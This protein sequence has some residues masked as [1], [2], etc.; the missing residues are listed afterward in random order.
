M[1]RI[2]V[3]GHG[4]VGHRFCEKLVEHDRDRRHRLI[5]FGREPRPAYDRVHLTEYFAHRDASRLRLGT[6]AWY[7]QHGIELRVGTPI[8]RIDR[9]R[10][11]VI[12]DGGDAFDYD[13][14]VLAT[15]SAPFVPP[16]HG[17]DTPG[18]YVYRTIEDLD[19]IAAQLGHA[20]RAVV[21]GGGLLGLEAA[22]AVLDAGLETHVLEV[23]PRLMP[24]QLDAVGGALLEASIRRLGVHV[25]LGARIAAITGGD[26]VREV[27]LVGEPAIPADLV[28]VSAGIQPCDEL[29]RDAGILTGERGGV[30]VD[31]RLRTSDEHVFAIGEVALHDGTIY[32]LVAPGY[33]MAE[34]LARHLIGEDAAFRGA[35]RS[36]K[37]KLLGTDVA[38]FGDPFRDPRNTKVVAYEDQLRGV[39]QKLVL[40]PDGRQLVG[41]ILVGDTQ[42]YVRLVHLARTGVPVDGALPVF[43]RSAA[44]S[45]ELADDAP[46]CSC[47]HVLAG[48]IRA[49][50]RAASLSTVA[51]I[52]GCTRAG[53]G[54]GGCLPVVA[55]LLAA[56]LARSGRA[57]K[58]V[59]CEH[60]AHSRQELFEI[61]AAT[62]IR[63]FGALI[64]A[65]GT[66]TGCEVCKPTVAS[67]LA[68]TYNEPVLAPPHRSLQDS[69][70]RFLAN[71]QKNG[72][73]SV[74]PRIPAGEVTPDQLIAIGQVARRYG[75]YTKITGG[76]RIDLFGARL[77]QLPEIWQE[78][79]AAGFESGHAYGKAMRTVKSC[80][81][82]TWCRYG[83]QDSTALAIRVEHRYKG[84]RA[85]HKLKGAVSGCVRECAEAQ[86]KD[87]G[88]IATERGWNVHVCGN[89]GAKPRHAEL[90][91]ADVD[92]DTAIRLLDR[93]IMFYVSTADRLTRTSVWLDKMTG[94]I[95]H[96]RDVVVNDS[97]GVAAELERRMQ[98]LVDTYACEWRD[99]VNDPVKRA[100]F[101][102]FAN[103][104][105]GDDTIASVVERGQ[106][107]PAGADRPADALAKLRRLPV[108]Q[109]SFVRLASVHDVPADGGIAVRYGDAQIAIFRAARGE[110]YATQ[111]ECPHA[112]EMVL[113]RSIVGD[114]HGAPKI[115]C[116]LHK[117]TFDLRSGACL[118]A[119]AP[120]ILTFAVRV[121]GDDVYVELP[122]TDE[123]RAAA[124]RDSR[125]SVN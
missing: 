107:R 80:V 92:E 25:H 70:D 77:E 121:D 100:Q 95:A 67:I 34:V 79:I 89:G 62:G 94:G 31:D 24:R 9:A 96:L 118:S 11:A 28:I 74:V 69:N 27:E 8:V 12:A 26:R 49:G 46:V 47:N 22:R 61:V 1:R 106:R 14:L 71:I 122:P 20:R 75:L 48:A 13:A 103:D 109:R 99:V 63:T 101:R 52:K 3:I 105:G 36:A 82:S 41:G 72:T 56:E 7:A 76:Q 2:V 35:D 97:L 45:P 43:G 53:T 86:S 84:I 113:G 33:E 29:A 19:A 98:H 83:V 60:F 17:I 23:A 110:W 91:A 117:R 58:Q 68:S 32:G 30:V 66:G 4:M 112:H 51:E 88:L 64:D 55:D 10:R 108:L 38:S 40:T 93:F 123:L 90:L 15:G 102:H 87:F 78:L 54:C 37:L 42:D 59:L 50:I 119:D 81:G 44:A 6:A 5:V 73:Y 21:I 104:A 111:N 65:H 114:D 39:Y 16:V 124:C 116:P 115:A 85:P 18:V 125:S 57:A 120:D